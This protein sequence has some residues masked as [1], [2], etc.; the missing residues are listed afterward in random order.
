MCEAS[1]G[2]AEVSPLARHK[3]IAGES[4]KEIAMTTIL[5]A[6]AGWLMLLSAPES[7]YAQLSDAISLTNQAI[8][9][10]TDLPGAG[11]RA[12]AEFSKVGGAD[13]RQIAK[14]N[15]LLRQALDKAKAANASALAI[16]KL[17]EAI[18]ASAHNQHKEP[19]LYAQGALYHLCQG[20]GGPGCDT[21][22]KF[23]SYVAP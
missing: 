12:Q 3:P 13:V 4:R 23:G 7:A 14:A 20:A 19:R 21:V 17:E 15:N 5:V 1:L 16:M 2:A 10:L 11:K 9:E 8:I 22:P 18:E 6:V